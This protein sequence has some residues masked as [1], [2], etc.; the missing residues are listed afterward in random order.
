MEIKVWGPGKSWNLRV[1]QINRLSLGS[2]LLKQ[3]ENEFWNFVAFKVQGIPAFVSNRTRRTVSL[4]LVM[5]ILQWL[6]LLLSIYKVSNC[7]S[8]IHLYIWTLLSPGKMWGPRKVVEFF[9]QESGTCFM[10]FLSTV[11]RCWCGYL[12]G[13]RCR[14]HLTAVIWTNVVT[15]NLV[16]QNCSAFLSAHMYVLAWQTVCWV[17]SRLW[18]DDKS[19]VS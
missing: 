8:T 1:V 3:S 2:C 14:Q 4:Q 15:W 7:C 18:T 10:F 9:G 11:M 12:S 16:F 5:D 6:I 13:P 17:S 19:V